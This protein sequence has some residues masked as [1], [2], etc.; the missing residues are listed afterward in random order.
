MRQMPKEAFTGFARKNRTFL[1]I[2]K[3]GKGGYVLLKNKYA[4]PQVGAVFS[5]TES[6]IIRLIQENNETIISKYKLTETKEKQRRIKKSLE[7]IPQLAKKLGITLKVPT[8]EP[9]NL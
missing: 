9:Y 7:Y 1:W 2:K 3:G 8:D 5:G 6:E 4:I